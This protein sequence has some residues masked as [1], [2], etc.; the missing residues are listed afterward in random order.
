[1][2][3]SYKYDAFIS[4]RHTELDK[5]VAENLHK[6]LEAFRLPKSIAKRHQG[7]KNK[8]ERVF[9]DK[10]ELPLTSNLEDPIVQALE[11][12][13]WL[14][15][16][17]SPRLRES[18]WCKKEIETFVKLR[19]RERVLAVLIEG[20]PA[21]SFPDELLFKIEK[22]TL[23]DGTVEEIKVPVEPLAA[24]VRGKTKKEV[25][26]AMKT[27]V[28]RL[29]AA[30]FR[31]TY[32][33]LRQ[34]HRERRMRR[35][36]TASLI[37]GAACLLFGLYSTATALRIHRQNEQIS[38]QSEEIKKQSD[39]ISKQNEELALRQA[40]SLA[41]LAGS[42]LEDGNRAAAIATATEALTESEGIALPYTPEA[43]MILTESVRAYDTGNVMRAE[44]QYETAGKIESVKASPDKDT[45]CIYDGTGS[46]T[47]F[48]LEKREVIKVFSADEYVVSGDY[49]CTFL[50]DDKFVYSDYR[51]K[52]CVFD[53]NTR[54]V[55]KELEADLVPELH[56][57]RE[58]KYLAVE[59]WKKNC[60]IY[61]GETFEKLGTT[62]EIET[63][64][65]ADGPY[66]FADGVFVYAYSTKNEQKENLYTIYFIDLKTMEV[67]ST[68]SLN[69]RE[70]KDIEV[71]DGIAY[72]VTGEYGE[73][74][75]DCD[76][77]TSAIDIAGGNLLWECEH[78][79]Y[80]PREI[81]YP[82]NDGAT[83]LLSITD[84]TAYLTDIQT[85]TVKA[86]LTLPS[87]VVSS[88]VYADMNNFLLY[89]E[90]GE[91]L[92]VSSEH[93]SSFDM[94]HLFECKSQRNREILHS[95]HGT[96]VWEYND[97]KVTVYAQAAGPDVVPTDTVYELPEST[98]EINGEQAVEIVQSYGLER[99][100]F[101]NTLYYSEDNKYCFIQYWDYS[102]AI[103][104]TEEERLCHTIENAYPTEWCLGTDAEGFTYLLGYYGCYVLNQDMVPVMWIEEANAVDFE[105]KKVYLNWN[106][107]YYE[108]PIY[109]VEELIEIAK[110]RN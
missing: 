37:G 104:N 28:L 91:M 21:D 13:E 10:E 52:V 77:Y 24:D 26:K 109:T 44:Y 5:F 20:E 76:A 46:L 85:G 100:E 98:E 62:P 69:T 9:R 58:G 92:V 90:S 48:D 82:I 29:L 61:D 34:R 23:P 81:T 93:N 107:Q 14:I 47:L 101:V 103:Y 80:Y 86:V 63:T 71:H 83:N 78:E 35:I 41:E 6:Q 67:I 106:S 36:L 54:S 33:D 17:C 99:P 4:Y 40:R 49:G 110:N 18:M 39:E 19:G 55:I 51:G 12:S 15:V 1:M 89:C 22:R 57:D 95:G 72:M 53:L 64:A 108:A 31:L 3:S 42:Y 88:Y 65:Y 11:N 94:S 68:Y 27:E 43:Q 59:T 105:N 60:D 70:L 73:Y 79:N 7:E 87:E 56:A 75:A 25:L 8:I 45:I 38:A 102:V 97:K 96:V 16:I 30:M 32:D 74:Y 66:L 50:G 2:G 84:T